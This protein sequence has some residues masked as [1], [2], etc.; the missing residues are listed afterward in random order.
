MQI[1][2]LSRLLDAKVQQLDQ[3][4]NELEATLKH[5]S[6]ADQQEKLT[7]DIAA[8]SQIRVKLTKS[9]EIAW[10]AH[11]LQNDNND[12]ARARQRLLGISLCGI[13]L[14]AAGLLLAYVLLG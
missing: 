14:V 10:R 11:Q 7:T 1:Q 4:L 6:A 13:S 3:Q 12:E 8:L 9:K 5:T 2:E